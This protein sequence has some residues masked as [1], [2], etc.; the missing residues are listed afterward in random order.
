MPVYPTNEIGRLIG[1]NGETN[2][3]G[4]WNSTVYIQALLLSAVE[5]SSHLQHFVEMF[6]RI[7][8]SSVKSYSIIYTLH[9]CLEQTTDFEGA[10]Q[11]LI[12]AAPPVGKLN[13]GRNRPERALEKHYRQMETT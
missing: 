3:L 8:F 1:W 13:V 2:L 10:V 9:R 7:R 5:D 4:I 12:S 11:T 6:R